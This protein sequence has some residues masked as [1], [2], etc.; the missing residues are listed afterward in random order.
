MTALTNNQ[1]AARHYEKNKAKILEKKRLAY[2]AKKAQNQPVVQ[3]QTVQPVID[4]AKGTNEELESISEFIPLKS[5]Q[6]KRISV[7]KGM[8]MKQ[9]VNQPEPKN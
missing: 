9:K 2:A 3:S 1:R 5:A 4:N 8:N 7:I 6:E